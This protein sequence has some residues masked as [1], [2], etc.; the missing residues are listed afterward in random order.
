MATVTLEMYG[1]EIK[2]RVVDID[3]MTEQE[4]IAYAKERYANDEAISKFLYRYENERTVKIRKKGTTVI[5][6]FSKGNPRWVRLIR[7][8]IKILEQGRLYRRGKA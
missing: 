2:R 1:V 6:H 7:Q 3:E 5:L 4:I 8:R